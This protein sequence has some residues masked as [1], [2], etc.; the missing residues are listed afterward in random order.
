MKDERTLYGA[1]DKSELERHICS[2]VFIGLVMGKN[3]AVL[4]KLVGLMAGRLVDRQNI[5]G[6]QKI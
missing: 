1:V 2:S 3:W 6:F 5:G 4:P